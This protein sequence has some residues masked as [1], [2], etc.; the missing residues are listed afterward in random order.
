MW[1]GMLGMALLALALNGCGA[2][3]RATAKVTATPLAELAWT[4]VTLPIPFDGPGDNLA[5]SPVDGHDAWMC[6]PISATTY[7]I[8]KTTDAGQSWRQ[9]GRFSYRAPLAGAWCGLSADQTGTSALLA[10]IGWGC[11]ECGT[12]DS[13]S[14]FSADGTHWAPLSGY[15]EG[16]EF[17]TVR[18]G[19]I[20]VVTKAPAA[21]PGAAQYLAFSADGFQTWR[22][23]APHGLPTQ[24]FRFAVSPDDATLIGAG[25][26]GTLWRSSDLGAHWTR[27]PSPNGQTGLLIWLPQRSTF[28]LCSDDLS[29]RNYMECSTDDGA[30]WSQV[31]IL[32]Y[33]TP[34]P[35]PGKCG[36][37]V[38]TQ[39]QQCGPAGI[40]S[41]GTMI[42]QCLPNQTTPLPASGPSSTIVYLLPLGATTWR[43][44]GVTQCDVRVVP[45]SGPFW[46]ADTTPD[47]PLGYATGQLPG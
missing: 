17:A 21:Q 2:A 6:Q 43:P 38:T 10:T 30:H 14:L 16:G 18:G 35:V 23:M 42:T 19:V 33:T 40:E 41:D 46:C 37:G 20:A 31:N 44:I 9:T 5:I 15:V 3:A 34:C 45:A 24:F 36:Q 28:L 39:T 4:P 8:W 22:A 11:G 47:Q 1:L 32:S 26:D 29:A 27:L 13:A 12:L 7:L 25:Y